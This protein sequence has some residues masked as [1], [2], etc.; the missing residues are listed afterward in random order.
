MVRTKIPGGKLTSEQLLAE[1][2]LCD[3]VGNTTLRITTRQGLQLHGVLKSNLKRAIARINEIQLSTLG[4]CGDVNRNVMC[5]PAPYHEQHLSPD[6]G[7]GRPARRA[8]RPA[9]HGLSRNLAHRQQQ[10]AKS[11]SS[12]ARPK[13]T[14]ST[15][16]RSTASSTCR[17]SSRWPS[18]ARTTTASISMPTTSACWPITEGDKIVGYNV[19]V[20]GGMGVT[21]SAK[22]TFPAVAKRLC[23]V[24]PDQVLAGRR[25]R[26]Q[27]AARLRQPRRPQARP[28]QVRDRQLGHRE[29]QGQ[30]RRILRRPARRSASRPTSTAST[31]TWAGTSR[32][33]AAGST[34]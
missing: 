1:L 28:P 22:K 20:G 25:S 30:G 11:N 16:S 4:A 19:L 21:P 26:L 17:A 33:T 23:Y 2:D 29:V 7:A 32:A 6:A 12:A 14:A 27:G 8:L 31:T 5:C 13:A 15:S 34:A 3:E 18:A 10:P 24:T 9:H